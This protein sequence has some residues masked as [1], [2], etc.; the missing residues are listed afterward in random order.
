MAKLFVTSDIH[1]YFDELIDALD[2]AGFDKDN[3]DHWLIVCGDCFDR[4][5]NPIQTMKYLRML[6]RYIIIKGNHESLL[7]E[8]CER[9]YF[10]Q[11]DISNGTWHTICEFGDA[12]K[13]YDF[14]ECCTRTIA[15]VGHFIDNMVDYF[16]TKNYVFV[17]GFIPVSCD[18]NKPVYYQK[19][20]KFSKMEDWR[21]ANA[22]QW[23][24]A[25]WLNGMKMVDDGISTEKCIVVGHYHT[26]WGRAN[27]DGKPEFGDDADFSPYYYEDKLIAI[28][29]CTAYSGKVNVLVLEDEFLE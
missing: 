18:D 19:K 22:E 28:D 4:G 17:H 6:E 16:E 8:C 13:G 2:K 3:P 5:P 11:H 29:A 21:N 7:L 24:Q 1:S 20:R 15:R 27:F 25:R 26:S 9:K 12:D 14:G 23:E 10:C